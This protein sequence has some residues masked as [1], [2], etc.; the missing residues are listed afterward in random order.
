MQENLIEKYGTQKG[1]LYAYFGG[2]SRVEVSPP[3]K[4]EYCASNCCQV[5]LLSYEIC[6]NL[7][8]RK[9]TLLP[10]QKKKK[11]LFLCYYS[12]DTPNIN[13]PVPKQKEALV[14]IV[15]KVTDLVKTVVF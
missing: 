13:K 14:S 1:C 4:N 3:D 12:Y 2:R 6:L 15:L 9:A 5:S 10:Q 11:Q 8:L 7:F